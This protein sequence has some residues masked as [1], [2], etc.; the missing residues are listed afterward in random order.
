MDH[1]GIGAAMQSLVRVYSQSAR[2]TGRT[3]ALVE[4]AKE[5]D[6]FVFATQ[7]EADRVNRACLERGV[8]IECIVVNPDASHT[9]APRGRSRGRT[10]FDHSWVEQYYLNALKRCE[11]DIDFFQSELSGRG[12]REKESPFWEKETERWRA[13]I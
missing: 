1:F 12:Q 2:R 11:V 13:F 9:L 5:G 8:K 7:K 4:G 6:R 10:T 3:T